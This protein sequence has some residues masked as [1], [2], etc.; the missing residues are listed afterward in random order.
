MLVKITFG[1]YTLHCYEGLPSSEQYAALRSDAQII[2]DYGAADSRQTYLVTVRRGTDA[3]FLIAQ[4]AY[5]EPNDDAPEFL[6]IPETHLL[7]I[8]ADHFAAAYKLDKPKK[9]WSYAMSERF[10]SL[11]RQG[12][13]I[14]IAG[15]RQLGAW[16]IYGWKKWLVDVQSPWEYR[17]KSQQV[18]LT[19]G[20]SQMQFPLDMGPL[21]LMEED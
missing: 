21:E 15:M 5:T 1:D 3:P 11:T 10:L 12:E 16:D 17:I 20:G 6:F 18:Q 2:N 8:G 14:L 19:H 4:F 9:L 7:F 13:F